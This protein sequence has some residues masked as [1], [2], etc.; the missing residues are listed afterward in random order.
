LEK[1]KENR[2]YTVGFKTKC[3]T[4][5]LHVVGVVEFDVRIYDNLPVL[6][7]GAEKFD[8]SGGFGFK[9]GKPPNVLKRNSRVEKY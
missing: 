7:P 5:Y 6:K 4:K 3:G 1:Y 8:T 2:N 9:E